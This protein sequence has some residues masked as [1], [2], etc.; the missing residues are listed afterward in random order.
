M[1]RWVGL[2]FLFFICTLAVT[3]QEINRNKALF[4]E[5][6]GSGGFGS[7][8]Y[9]QSFMD[10]EALALSWRL[11][12]SFAPIDKL[13]GTGIVFPLMVSGV[14]GRTSHKLEVALGQGIT[15]TTKGSYYVLTTAALGYRF[16]PNYSPWFFRATYTPL[17]SYLADFQMQQWAGLS[18]GYRLNAKKL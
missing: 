4:F 13:N 5:L 15:I 10:R 11:G 12:L 16:Q 9:E 6:G 1:F 7:I 17:I 2:F 14:F 8:N 3:G 18:I